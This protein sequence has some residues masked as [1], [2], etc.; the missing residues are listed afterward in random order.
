MDPLWT[1]LNK[2][3]PILGHFFIHGADDRKF[4]IGI[5]VCFYGI[6]GIKK[7]SK[8]YEKNINGPIYGPT[9]GHKKMGGLL[10]PYLRR[11]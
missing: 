6:S 3:C 1:H 9:S 5:F 4:Q 11:P 8:Q 7:V 10:R 2:K